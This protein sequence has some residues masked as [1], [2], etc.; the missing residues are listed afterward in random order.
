[1]GGGFKNWNWIFLQL[2]WFQCGFL[3][4]SAD[5]RHDE[6]GVSDCREVKWS[7]GDDE[8]VEND[9]D[10]GVRKPT[11]Q[12]PECGLRRTDKYDIY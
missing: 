3:T 4:V 9:D 8:D 11:E 5:R 2:F 10:E 1:M 12:F 6:G 7:S